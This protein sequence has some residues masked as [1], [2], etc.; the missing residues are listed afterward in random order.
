ME[1]AHEAIVRQEGYWHGFEHYDTIETGAS[2]TGHDN[3]EHSGR[4]QMRVIARVAWQSNRPDIAI[5]HAALIAD[6]RE[7]ARLRLIGRQAFALELV[8]WERRRGDRGKYPPMS[9]GKVGTQPDFDA[10]AAGHNLPRTSAPLVRT[11]L[12]QRQSSVRTSV[13]SVRKTV[14]ISMRRQEDAKVIGAD[15]LWP[16]SGAFGKNR[17]HGRGPRLK[18]QKEYQMTDNLNWWEPTLA[19]MKAIVDCLPAETQGKIVERLRLLAIVQEDR[20]MDVASYFSRALSGETAPPRGQVAQPISI[21]ERAESMLTRDFDFQDYLQPQGILS[22]A[23]KQKG[24]K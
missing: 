3:D 20:G 19:A 7:R 1:S 8:E 2:G 24:P 22:A 15:V 9:A 17:H 6:R 18:Q 21:Y 10:A 16:N 11:F 5:D 14:P 13:P 4:K 23:L 12:R